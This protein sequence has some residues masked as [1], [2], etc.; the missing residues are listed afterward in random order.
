MR[1][2]TLLG[3]GTPEIRFATAGCG[4][5]QKMGF[6]GTAKVGAF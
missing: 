6:S 5:Q 4:C 3:D 1:L 2:P